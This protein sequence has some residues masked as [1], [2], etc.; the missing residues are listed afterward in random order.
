MSDTRE[1]GP[2]CLVLAPA[3]VPPAKRSKYAND[4]AAAF[5]RKES[6][7]PH[8]GVVG[9]GP[10]MYRHHHDRCKKRGDA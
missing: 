10:I 9:R 8:C 2:A 3:A 5:G 7:C 6:T 1:G 4:G